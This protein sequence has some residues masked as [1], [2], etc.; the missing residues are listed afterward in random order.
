MPDSEIR[1]RLSTVAAIVALIVA[2]FGGMA[3]YAVTLQGQISDVAGQ[4]EQISKNVHR[5]IGFHLE[6]YRKAGGIK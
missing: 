5:L 6:Q 2:L 3:G 1:I 4:V